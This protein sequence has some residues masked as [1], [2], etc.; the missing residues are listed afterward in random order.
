MLASHQA[1]D[2][3]GP[4]APPRR[5]DP[6]AY[7][8]PG[9]IDRLC[10]LAGRL[11]DVA[12]ARVALVD[13]PGSWTPTP[14]DGSPC[15]V[16][17]DSARPLAIRDA[18]ADPG[19]AGTES[20]L[21][22][23]FVAYLGVPLVG[24]CGRVLGCFAA[25]GVRP[26][27]WGE[28]EIETMAD[29][30]A[31]IAAEIAHRAGCDR[32]EAE[33]RLL[34]AELGSSRV[35]ERAGRFDASASPWLRAVGESLGMHSA[36]F[37]CP[38]EPGG[39]LRLDQGW[40]S[41]LVRPDEADPG[42][43]E[44]LAGQI[45]AGGHAWVGDDPERT[46]FGFPLVGEA[47]GRGVILFFGA[48][49]AVDRAG[50]L[51]LAESL[52]VAIDR[53]EARHL[54]RVETDRMASIVRA[55]GD[56]IG[57]VGPDGRVLWRNEAYRRVIGLGPEETTAG[58]PFN[59]V[60]PDWAGRLI[61]EQGLPG[62]A[63]SGS[64]IGESALLDGSGREIPTSQLILAS[65]DGRGEIEFYVT[66]TRDISAQ[67]RVEAELLEKRRFSE[68]IVEATPAVLLLF[69]MDAKRII[70]ANGRTQDLLG[71]QPAQLLAMDIEAIFEMIHPADAPTLA[72][73][74]AQ[75]ERSEVDQSVGVE[76]RFRHSD[77]SYRWFQHRTVVSDRAA[78][79]RPTRT[80]TVLDE[81]TA[82][83]RAED[84]SRILF[85]KSSDAHLIFDEAE[86]ILD[87]NEATLKLMMLPDKSAL[88]G[89]HPDS[90]TATRLPDGTPYSVDRKEIGS[91]ARRDG[92]HRFD[93]WMARAD[94]QPTPCDVT[95]TEVEVGG[96]SV[97]LVVWHD[98]TER[99]RVEAE[100]RKAK[101]QAE[102]A[103]RA[104]GEFL[105]NMSHEIRTP[106]NGILGM[107]ELALETDLDPNQREYL[108]LVRSSA[109]ALLTVIDDVLD[110]SKIEAGMLEIEPIPFDLEVV[111]RD[112]IRIL[113][114]R[115][116]DKKVDLACRI[117]PEVSLGVVGDPGRLRQV[118]VNLVGNALKFTSE[119]RVEV[120]V[121]P[122]AAGGVLRFAVSDTGIGIPPGKLA[123]IFEP[124]EQ[125]DNST[126]RKYG[127]TGLGLAIS[128]KLIRLMGGEIEVESRPGLGSTFRFT[129]RM[130]RAAGLA[131]PALDR[132]EP[133]P[134][135]PPAVGGDG[136]PARR[137]RVLLADDQAVNR[138]VAAR[139]LE[140]L[141]HSA[142]VVGDGAEAVARL[143]D[144]A[145]DAVLMDVS[146]PGMDGFEAIAAIRAGRA[147]ERSGSVPIVALTAHAMKGD[148]ERCLAAGFDGYLAK[149]IRHD[150]LRL[151]LEAVGAAGK[152]RPAD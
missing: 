93:W 74:M 1:A 144:E 80:I 113:A 2:A 110:F 60:Y 23:G 134:A 107:T 21:A 68:G 122:G 45:R 24:P 82:R 69:D 48:G 135:P 87:C 152:A 73:L 86:G 30:A 131:P 63:R 119:G 62:A 40:R 9:P 136:P 28:S 42:R 118:L 114:L 8:S 111:I 12:S 112:L 20:L 117:A 102:A 126:T 94:G 51:D 39:P 139:M 130:G 149:P 36:E 133:A 150:A 71:R 18:R 146:M 140:R 56:F 19:R 5:A 145:F 106:M 25:F 105:A 123:T 120:V 96:R 53:S 52:R 77:G 132:A 16:V 14:P 128:V 142:V 44:G 61:R 58:L 129:A 54:A 7:P 29:L 32:R 50:L 103:S 148:R 121:E 75:L 11:L 116:Q 26:R 124:F 151:A 141:G 57:I 66:V 115:A 78:S 38:D 72:L 97:I 95:L 108:R 65:R 88:L 109:E 3:R 99:K 138:L 98:L 81:I 55:T 41:D 101:E 70:W 90:F 15:G 10:R 127:G 34:A 43:A 83:K 79:G 35:L 64:W 84:L 137:L 125:A 92:Q 4:S 17:I 89:K 27:A 104:K 6:L 143:G 31:S 49:P 100:L 33:V 91:T 147:G 47:E 37:W 13:R 67:K 46:A 85:E 22:A 76:C 59:T